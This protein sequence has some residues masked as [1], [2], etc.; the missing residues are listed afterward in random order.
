[1][2]AEATQLRRAVEPTRP[3]AQPTGRVLEEPRS[4][5]YLLLVIPILSTLACLSVITFL[6]QRL[7]DPL[8]GSVPIQLHLNK[9]VWTAAILGTLG[10]IPN[11]PTSLLA[12]GILV[13]LAPLTSYWSSLYTST[14][15][16]PV[17]GPVVIHLVVLF[18]I[19]YLGIAFVSHIVVGAPELLS[20]MF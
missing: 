19:I 17:V 15:G 5:F 2:A 14:W 12:T 4:P 16:N 3:P 10:P 6:Y 1:M 8:C 7:L 20:S 9:F 13:S 11:A 18:P